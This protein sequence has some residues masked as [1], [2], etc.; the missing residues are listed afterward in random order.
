[1]QF[2]VPQF[3]EI[4]TKIIGPIS[5]RQVIIL[6]VS[7]GIIFLLYELLASTAFIISS[8]FVGV[9]AG[10]FAFAKINSQPF[11]IFALN[12]IQTMKTPNLRVWNR[13][14][15]PYKERVKKEKKKPPKPTVV[16]KDVTSSRLT[17]LSL[18]VDTGGRYQ[19][20]QQSISAQ[21]AVDKKYASK[22]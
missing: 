19:T 16:K 2:I 7:G 9:L 13:E 12:F 21:T 11:H 1:M 4:E 15:R 10:T 18:Q 5:V 17:E 14:I 22:K 3:I 20:E 6:L 8:L